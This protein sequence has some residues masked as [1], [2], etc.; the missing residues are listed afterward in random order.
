MIVPLVSDSA[1]WTSALALCGVLVGAG[2]SFGATYMQE[3]GIHRRGLA[4]RWDDRRIAAYIAYIEAVK[5][6]FRSMSAA[7]DVQDPTRRVEALNEMR[8]AEAERS[9]LFESLMLLAGTQTRQKAHE[10]NQLVWDLEEMQA[11]EQG[12]A[13]E[14]FGEVERRLF[15]KIGEFHDAARVD[16]GVDM[17]IMG[18][19]SRRRGDRRDS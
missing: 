3:R 16:L 2:A 9:V 14:A 12:K 11:T 15:E 8:L 13:D 5:K 18:E 6:I 4:L 17:T 1:L 10:L 19:Q 7:V